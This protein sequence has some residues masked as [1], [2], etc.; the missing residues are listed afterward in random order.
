[1][2]TETDDLVW[3]RVLQAISNESG[4]E[5]AA[6]ACAGL[7]QSS[8]EVRRQACVYMAAHPDRRHVPW[9]LPA[10]EDKQPLVICAAIEALA[11]GGMDDPAPLKP[12]LNSTSEEIQLAVAIALVRLNDAGGKPALERLAYSKDSQIRA[13][14]ARAL[15]EYPD[16]EFIPILIRYLSDQAAIARAALASLPKVVGEDISQPANHPQLPIAE[17]ISRWKHWFERQESSKQ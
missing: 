13:Q 16:P 3:L 15:G 2:Q 12:L 7:S 1:M 14:V 4:E 17:R 6:I 5:A 8:S 10:L 11:A 9:L